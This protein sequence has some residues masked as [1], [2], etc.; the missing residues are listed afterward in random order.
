MDR[1]ADMDHL[2][3]GI[4]SA[5]ITHHGQY[6]DVSLKATCILLG[7]WGILS[8]LE[9]AANF[10]LF[11]AGGMLDWQILALRPSKFIRSRTARLIF[12]ER[13]TRC[14]LIVRVAAAFHL[15]CHGN[16]VEVA[17]SSGALVLT[18]WLL[19]AR[20]WL[21]GDGS[22]QMGQIVSIGVLLLASGLAIDDQAVAFAG[23]L[24]I[25]GQATLSYFVAGVAKLISPI[26][27]S[28]RAS[29]RDEYL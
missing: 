22:D 15:L 17:M 12:S 11:Q 18:Y 28:A 4:S 6:A 16:V 21:G 8:T 1:S 2:H 5:V 23:T 14:V 20:S 7:A 3:F 10:H 27:R 29:A 24:L 25:G 26:W 9:W 19:S 13:G